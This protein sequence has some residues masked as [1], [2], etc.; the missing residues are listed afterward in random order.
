MLFNYHTHTTFS[1]GKNTPEEIVNFAIEKG[2]KALGF[3]DHAFTEHDQRY[4]MKD[5]CGYAREVKR[6]K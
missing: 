3:S 2:L 4:C 5:T 6:L 1:D